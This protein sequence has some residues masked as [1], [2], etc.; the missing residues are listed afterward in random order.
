MPRTLLVTAFLLTMAPVAGAHGVCDHGA[1]AATALG[2]LYLT[3]E[4]HLYQ[5]SNGHDGLQRSGGTC[6]DENGRTGSWSADTILF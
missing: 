4:G 2:P 6:T 3:A 5:E 1:D